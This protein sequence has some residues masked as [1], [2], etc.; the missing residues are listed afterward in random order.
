M[1]AAVFTVIPLI[2]VCA[3]NEPVRDELIAA[4]TR[5]LDSGRFILGESVAAFEADLA[6]S[7]GAPFA[8]GTSSGT[9]GLLMTLMALGV[10]P[11]DEVI[12]TPFTFFATV[13][14]I[15]RLGATPV[16]ADVS[17]TTALISPDAVAA[18]VSPRTVGIIPVHL[19]GACADMT[20]ISHI[21]QRHRLWVV[22]DAAQALGA[23]H[24]GA[25][26]GTI[27]TA[28]VYSFFPAKSLGALGDA[29]AV[30]TPDE[31]L[32]D[33][34]RMLRVHGAKEKYRHEMAGGNFR[35]DALQAE[36]LRVKLRHLAARI[37]A[38]RAVAARYLA[39]FAD[40]NDLQ[41]P[42]ES[43]GDFSLYQP[44]VLRAGRRDELREALTRQ[45]IETAVYYPEPLHLS[46][47][48]CHPGHGRRSFPAAEALS[49]HTLALPCGAGLRADDQRRIIATVIAAATRGQ[50]GEQSA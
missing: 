42:G 40:R 4:F 9:D 32:N 35:M 36:L 41:M 28:G 49:R 5:V 10:K 1:S 16:F 18:A 29:G 8:V 24:Q 21:A 45:G 11:G 30:V 17:P 7:T 37:S 3:D 19:F 34:L 12:T 27:G 33:R 50:T 26:A 13:G 22:E 46:A 15:V 44:F 47:A 25:M 14:A 23:R 2:D 20:A 38:R 6:Q 43:A 48:L 39:A 31:Q